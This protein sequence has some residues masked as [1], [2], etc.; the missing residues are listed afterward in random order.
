MFDEISEH[1]GSA[2]L[3]QKLIIKGGMWFLPGLF[4]KLPDIGSMDHES[5][6]MH[7]FKKMCIHI[8]FC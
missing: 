4:P 8:H 1:H 2:K 7:I 5:T 3:T 6:K